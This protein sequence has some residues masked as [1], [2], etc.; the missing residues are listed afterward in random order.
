M[1]TY[2]YESAGVLNQNQFLAKIESHFSQDFSFFA[3]YTYG[4]AFAT[5]DGPGSFPANQYDLSTEYGRSATDVRHRFF[6]VEQ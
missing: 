6:F 4:Q 5:T 3:Q 1:N 2:A